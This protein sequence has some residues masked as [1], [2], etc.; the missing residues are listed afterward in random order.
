MLKLLEGLGDVF[1]H[2]EADG[3]FGIVPVDVD[4][5]EEQAVPV[6]D[7]CGVFIEGVLQV[8]DVFEGGGFNAKKLLTLRQNMISRCTCRQSPGVC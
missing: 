3:A 8:H 7:D 2:V 6:H 5:A 1:W 4:A